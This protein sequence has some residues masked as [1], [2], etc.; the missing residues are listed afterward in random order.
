MPISDAILQQ[1]RAGEISHLDLSLNTSDETA[2]SLTDDDVRLIANAC[3]KNNSLTAIDL[4]RNA[5]L[6]DAA[7]THLS[8]ITSLQEILLSATH[9]T[10]DCLPL[11]SNFVKL[12][13]VALGGCHNITANGFVTFLNACPSLVNLYI[14]SL[15]LK[16][17]VATAIAQ[18][19]ELKNLSLAHAYGLTVQFFEELIKSQSI[20]TLNLQYCML[21]DGNIAPLAQST[22]I[23][24]VNVDNNRI[25]D[26]GIKT[27]CKMVNLEWLN[28]T[29]N[30]ITDQGLVMLVTCKKLLF[31]AVD[32]QKTGTGYGIK[33]HP[34]LLT[35]LGDIASRNELI[36]KGKVMTLEVQF[37]EILMVIAQGARQLDSAWS[38]L[39]MELIAHVFRQACDI[40]WRSK[41][42]IENTVILVVNNL[43]TS[44]VTQL[45]WNQCLEINKTPVRFFK[46][47]EI[48]EP[49]SKEKSVVPK[50]VN[51]L[52]P[53]PH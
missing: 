8:R 17:R 9:I 47:Y 3:A 21:G 52:P 44:K 4:S 31:C 11:F 25:T 18:L 1:L 30:Q 5:A 41:P 28:A 15:Q 49:V 33:H 20:R 48:P 51:G 2:I 7:I 6:T 22:K 34:K 10:D 23:T 24:K 35:E 46:K 53:K 13:K 40:E 39:P 14:N 27:L 38:L 16:P 26:E 43:R 36:H 19:R 42:N 29:G 45:V 50:E 12:Y 32:K 37:I